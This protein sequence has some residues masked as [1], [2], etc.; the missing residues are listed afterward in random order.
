MARRFRQQV[1]DEI[2][3]RAAAL[4]AQHGFAQTSLKSLADAAGLSK[5]G[6]LHH[7]PSKEALFEAAQ[8]A[9]R[10]R[11]R[12]LL[13][14]L[15]DLPPGQERDR[16]ALELLT[17]LALDRPGWVALA[18]RSFTAA[19]ADDTTDEQFLFVSEMFAVDP[20][21]SEPERLVRVAGALSAMAVLSLAANRK[22]EKTTWRPHIIAT[23]FDA[24]G[25]RR[26]DASSSRSHQVEA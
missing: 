1:D 25:H 11:G 19:D 6:L 22:G 24:L 14:Q 17:D 5:A 20:T 8:E 16:R 3:D 12:L 15:N 21:G 18:F 9:G 4:F 7:Y 2:L 26:P 23:C 13:D 10:E